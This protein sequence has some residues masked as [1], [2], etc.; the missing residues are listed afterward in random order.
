MKEQISF[1]FKGGEKQ[2]IA[3]RKLVQHRQIH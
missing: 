3:V 1:C 2:I